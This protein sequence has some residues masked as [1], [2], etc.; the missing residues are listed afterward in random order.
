MSSF[1]SQTIREVRITKLTSKQ[2]RPHVKETVI[3]SL[4]AILQ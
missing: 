1:Y 2:D 4:D 3:E